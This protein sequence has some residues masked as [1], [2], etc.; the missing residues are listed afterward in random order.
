[1]SFDLYLYKQ[2]GRELSQEEIAGY[3]TENLT[4]PNDE[5]TQWWF[6][7][8]ETGVYYSFMLEEAQEDDP[9]WVKMYGSFAD[10]GNTGFVFSLNFVRPNFFGME[11]FRFV[12]RFMRDLDLYVLNPQSGLDTENPRRETFESLYDDWSRPN[13]SFSTAHFDEIQLIHYPL[14]RSNDIWDFSFHRSE[15]Q[16]R[17]GDDYFVSGALF[18]APEDG[19]KAAT[20][21]TWTQHIPCVLPP[22][23]YV[24]INRTRKKLFRT[25]K[26]TG[27]VSYETLMSSMGR[28]FEN[29]ENKGKIIHP[30]N[31]ERAGDVFTSLPFEYEL[32][33][34]GKQIDLD[35]LTNAEPGA[36]A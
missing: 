6:E 29:Y 9:E 28:L 3:L 2:K 11:A 5:G 22:V 17:L 12:E 4:P 13:L 21:T 20:L 8:E 36:E 26:E 23:D 34:L 24:A 14:E 19:R 1:M 25:V 30:D 10:F 31:A 35:R 33:Q 7:N 27:I 15:M 16:A 32:S 18:I